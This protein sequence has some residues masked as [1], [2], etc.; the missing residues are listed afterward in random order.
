MGSGS[1]CPAWVLWAKA[2]L[3]SK[4]GARVE[5]TSQIPEARR[6]NDDHGV[7]TLAHCPCNLDWINYEVLGNNRHGRRT[8]RGKRVHA[9]ARIPQISPRPAPRVEVGADDSCGEVELLEAFEGR[10]NLHG[11]VDLLS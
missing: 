8:K 10:D 4:Q 1:A 9:V 7:R 11:V 3:H 2:H 6:S 5:Q